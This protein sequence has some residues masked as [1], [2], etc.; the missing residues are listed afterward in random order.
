MLW[1][2]SVVKES[3]FRDSRRF[4]RLGLC[5]AY[6][7]KNLRPRRVIKEPEGL[8]FLPLASPLRLPYRS[9][10]ARSFSAPQCSNAQRRILY[11]ILTLIPFQPLIIALS[12]VF[13]T[14]SMADRLTTFLLNL[15]R[16]RVQIE[17]LIS[18]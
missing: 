6:L 18:I 13:L 7:K 8:L 12:L 3:G 2:R 9:R 17:L 14:I 1:R 15:H 5:L 11:A 16:E 10:A 4:A